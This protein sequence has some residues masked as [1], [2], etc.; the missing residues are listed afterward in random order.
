MSQSNKVIE[1]YLRH[2]AEPNTDLSQI[3]PLQK[4]RVYRQAVVIPAFNESG[5]FITRLQGLRSNQLTLFIIVLNGSEDRTEEDLRNTLMPLRHLQS[6]QKSTLP[7][8]A[9]NKAGLPLYFFQQPT[10]DFLVLDL[11]SRQP[12][13]QSHYGVGYARKF[14]MDCCLWL[15]HQRR[16]FSPFVRNTDADV[17]WPADYLTSIP[18]PILSSDKASALLYPFQHTAVQADDT[19]ACEAAAL[20]DCWLRYYVAGLRWAQSP[21]AFHTV[22]STLVIHLQHYAIQRGFPKRQAGEDFYLLNK[23]AKSGD[24]IQLTKPVLGLS[25]RSSARTPFGTGKSISI[26]KSDSQASWRFYHPDIFKQLRYWQQ[27]LATLYSPTTANNKVGETLPELPPF[28][29]EF[30]PIHSALTA[31]KIDKLLLHGRTH[32]GNQAAFLRHMNIGFDASTTRKC[33]HWLRDHYFPSLTFSYL[34]EQINAG[35][36][37]FIPAPPS[38]I[39]SATEL[40]IYMRQLE[41]NTAV[42]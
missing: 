13:S 6:T 27:R 33:V 29:Q 18:E 32:S 21:W 4:S 28:P 36:I 11:I 40:S 19:D 39:S 10:H 14:G 30:T 24:I 2:Y 9:N 20:Y 17:S 16:L 42:P 35:T 38:R 22:G 25:N 1:K 37:P 15:Y 41:S 12:G 7:L 26:I 5:A 3:L 31:L 34:C 23:L 8:Q